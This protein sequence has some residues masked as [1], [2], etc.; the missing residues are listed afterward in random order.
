MQVPTLA[1][2]LL[3]FSTVFAP[4]I[5]HPST[6][7]PD[8]ARQMCEN[9]QPL[10]FSPRDIAALTM[11]VE[12]IATEP[13]SIAAGYVAAQ[14]LFG[15]FGEATLDSDGQRTRL[16]HAFG[17]CP[18]IAVA[19]RE[20][21]LEAQ[22]R[23]LVDCGICDSRDEACALCLRVP[24]V[25]CAGQQRLESA[26]AVR[27]VLK[28]RHSDVELLLTVTSDVYTG[29]LPKLVWRRHARCAA[30]LCSACRLNSQ[31]RVSFLIC[32]SL[33]GMRASCAPLV[34]D[35]L[36]VTAGSSTCP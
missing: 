4:R 33:D 9:L 1:T 27:T 19:A 34:L 15:A 2:D 8:W 21:R 11:H 31:R 24:E 18:R 16:Q 35:A 30:T 20:G 17:Q 26:M 14:A 10:G 22:L 25:S 32:D 29:T 3:R 13:A 6:A 7:L 12:L 36:A 5:V 28:L 23:R